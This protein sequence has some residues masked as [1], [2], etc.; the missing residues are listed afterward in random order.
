[1]TTD[2]TTRKSHI[3]TIVRSIKL[4]GEFDP[5][6]DQHKIALVQY[7]RAYNWLTDVAGIRP[8]DLFK[9][10]GHDINDFGGQ[11]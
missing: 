5:Q 6:T 4:M 11:S 9:L 10:A 2:P 3:E 1:M 8:V 7:R